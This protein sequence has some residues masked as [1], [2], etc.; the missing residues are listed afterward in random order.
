M[1]PLVF[2]RVLRRAWDPPPPGASQGVNPESSSSRRSATKAHLV[3]ELTDCV[4]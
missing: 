2:I 3:L 1:F 4:G